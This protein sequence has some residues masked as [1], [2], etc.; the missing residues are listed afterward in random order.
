MSRGVSTV[1][2]GLRSQ[3]AVASR[4]RREVEG[5]ASTAAAS[6]STR[7]SRRHRA[8]RDR[9]RPRGKEVSSPL[10]CKAAAAALDGVD[11]IEAE[12]R[13]FMVV[14]QTCD[15]ARACDDRP[16]V[17]VCPLVD[18]DAARVAEVAKVRRPRNAT[19]RG[20]VDR[21][22]AADPDRVM[23]VEKGVIAK[24]HEEGARPAIA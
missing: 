11:A 17:E 22:L 10:T 3:D 23:T 9:T 14:T 12:V 13:G 5:R 19:V 24:E 16:F 21:N 1:G 6:R 7:L 18:I 20:I 2:A 15:L 8:S 4:T